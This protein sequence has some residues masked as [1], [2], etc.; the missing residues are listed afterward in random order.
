MILLTVSMQGHTPDTSQSAVLPCMGCL[1]VT[2]VLPLPCLQVA[3]MNDGSFLVADG[4][5]NS[6]IVRFNP[7]GSHHSQYKLPDS[8]NKLD[9]NPNSGGRPMGVA[10]SVVLDECDGEVV[11]ADRENMHVLRF[12]MYS[13]ELRGKHQG[14]RIF[15][16]LVWWSLDCGAMFWGT[17]AVCCKHCLSVS[18]R[19][20]RAAQV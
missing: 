16:T 1:V 6:R 13:T 11:L 5:C 9:T 8:S 18:V 3:F 10:H 7:D 20:C 15:V 14:L 4:Y 12:D 2:D 17:T 19:Y